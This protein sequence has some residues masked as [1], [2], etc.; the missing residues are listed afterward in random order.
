MPNIWQSYWANR[1]E[2]HVKY[3]FC[4]LP[5]HATSRKSKVFLN[6]F[7]K[8]KGHD[9]SLKQFPDRFLWENIEHLKINHVA[10]MSVCLLGIH[11]LIPAAVTG[12]GMNCFSTEDA[13]VH[14]ALKVYCQLEP[15][16]LKKFLFRAKSRLL[17]KDLTPTQFS[18]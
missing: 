10:W 18:P 9:Y 16:T 11:S 5:I 14:T 15:D 8:M 2:Q 4:L 1:T 13:D 3:I 7:I 17:L 12:N 6:I